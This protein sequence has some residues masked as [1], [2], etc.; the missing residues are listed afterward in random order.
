MGGADIIAFTGSF[1]L[2]LTGKG[3]QGRLKEENVSRK[4]DFVVYDDDFALCL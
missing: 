3:G 2:L 1:S 4:L